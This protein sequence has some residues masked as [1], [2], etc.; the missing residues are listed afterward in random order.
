MNDTSKDKIGRRTLVRRSNYGVN[1]MMIV[2]SL[3]PDREN[4]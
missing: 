3:N 2:D 1:K 4:A